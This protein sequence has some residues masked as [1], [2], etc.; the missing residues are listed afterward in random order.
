MNFLIWKRG[1]ALCCLN[2]EISPPLNRLQGARN[3]SKL[4]APKHQ[5]V[6]GEGGGETSVDGVVYAHPVCSASL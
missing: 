5:G 6:A 2:I 4:A 3:T 1:R